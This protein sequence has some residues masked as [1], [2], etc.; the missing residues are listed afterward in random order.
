MSDAN[1]TLAILTEGWQTYQDQLS[2]ALAPLTPEQLA[3]RAAPDLRS[4]DELAR[5]IIAVRAGWFHNALHVGGDDFAAYQQWHWPDSP[6]REAGELVDGLAGTWRV[7][8][9]A[10]ARFT[11]EDMRASVEREREGKTYTFVR[12]WVVWHV[13]EHDLHHGGEIAYSLGMHGLKAPDI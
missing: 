7:L 8:R 9:E 2:Q 10:L 6:A 3:L 4:I 11:P 5:H 1:P 12:G 13:M